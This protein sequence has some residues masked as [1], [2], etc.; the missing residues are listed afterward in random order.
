[1]AMAKPMVEELVPGTTLAVTTSVLAL[2]LVTELAMA[3]VLASAWQS[4]L[5]SALG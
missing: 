5:G 2:A 3:M 4:G 1:M